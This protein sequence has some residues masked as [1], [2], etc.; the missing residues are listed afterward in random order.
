[1]TN[2]QKGTWKNSLLYAQKG[3][4]KRNFS[5]NSFSSFRLTKRALEKER[6]LRLL[7]NNG[8]PLPSARCQRFV[9][10]CKDVLM[11]GIGD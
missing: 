9:W 2:V 8:R 11:A 6:E 7:H 4:G 3:L 1:M 10:S 5:I